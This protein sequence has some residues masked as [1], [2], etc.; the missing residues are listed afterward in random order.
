[1]NSECYIVHSFPGHGV[2]AFRLIG[3]GFQASLALCS[4]RCSRQSLR[5]SALEVSLGEFLAMIFP[6][7]H[8]ATDND[9]GEWASYNTVATLL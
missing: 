9:L 1:M 4:L 3:S 2:F 8:K 7:H 5:R 6:S